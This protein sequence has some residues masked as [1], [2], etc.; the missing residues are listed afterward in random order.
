MHN[1]MNWAARRM[2]M[3]RDLNG[4]GTLFGG[5]MLE[6]IDEESAIYAA[7]KLD[8]YKLVTAHM[9]DINFL[10]PAYQNDIIEIGCSVAKI[11][12]T[13]ITIKCCV[14]NKRTKHE[15]ISVEQIVFVNLDEDGNP[16]P[17]GK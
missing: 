4:A 7:C 12:T 5:R 3:A 13:S 15:I 10:A 11:G 2:V 6:W 8:A 9:S 14:R 1:N 16:T 17:H